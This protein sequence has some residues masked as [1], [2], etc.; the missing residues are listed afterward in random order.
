MTTYNRRGHYRR[1]PNGQR[2]W[3]SSHTVSRSSGS[4]Y[5]QPSQGSTPFSISRDTRP[6]FRELP[7]SRPQ[8]LPRSIGW[9]KPNAVC[10][11]CG[12]F[13]YFY[14]NEHG[15]RVYFDE[16]GPPWP[17][18]PCTD[19]SE[20]S[21]WTS[22]KTSRISPALYSNAVGRGK[23]ASMPSFATRNAFIVRQEARYRHGTT[24]IHLQQLYSNSQEEVWETPANI[25]LEAGQ[26]V[27]VEGN[28]LSYVD[29]EKVQPVRASV[30]FL[31][32]ISKDSL[33]Q[34]LRFRW[35]R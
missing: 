19:N 15:S 17:K 30:R 14:A 5:I 22:Q 2:V 29:M 32:R 23:V 6:A 28:S 35:R 8:R 24:L 4:S 10:P 9:A 26:L 27:F 34:R 18:H 31:H 20:Q 13:V 33:L 3:V 25:S 21:S 7:S 16:I 1:G 12:A 11:V